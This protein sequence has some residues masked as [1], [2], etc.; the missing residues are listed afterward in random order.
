LDPGGKTLQTF[1][2][3]PRPNAG[4]NGGFRL[5]DGNTLVTG[6]YGAEVYEF[7]RN[8]R[9]VWTLTQ[10]DLPAGFNLHYLGTAQRLR[11]G[12]TVI[13]NFQGLPEVFEI[14]PDKR[15]VWQYH[16]EKI[17]A[18]SACLIVDPS[19]QPLFPSEPARP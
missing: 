1:V 3:P 6:G 8:A 17:G 5:P 19:A 2:L 9:I 10:A 13:S 18:I 12:H 16:N 7:D 14:T 15:V 4:A 11:D